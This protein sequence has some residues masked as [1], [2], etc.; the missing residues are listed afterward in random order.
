M[1]SS[2]Q[3]I[4]RVLIVAGMGILN[5][6][7]AGQAPVDAGGRRLPSKG[8]IAPEQ[9]SNLRALTPEQKAEQELA[10]QRAQGSRAR[11]ESP[12]ISGFGP[13]YDPKAPVSPGFYGPPDMSQFPPSF[14]EEAA[15]L[16]AEFKAEKIS[17]K[18]YQKRARD[19][20]GRMA[21]W[22]EKAGN[23]VPVPAPYDLPPMSE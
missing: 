22:K 9:F 19:M 7:A 14:S 11:L 18:E 15:A 17:A 1:T 8:V 16:S 5:Y 21:E 6:P 23:D 3:A 20:F 10:F 13:D 2:I 12:E 4:A